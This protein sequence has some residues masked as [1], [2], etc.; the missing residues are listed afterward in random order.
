VLAEGL[1]G[2]EVG[3][4]DLH[5]G[6]GLGLDGV[7]EGVGVVGEGPRVQDDG[8]KAL[9]VGLLDPVYELA[10]VVALPEDH[11]Q[12]QL[13]PPGLA[14]GLQLLQGGPSVKLGL[15]PSQE[16]QVGAVQDQDHWP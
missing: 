12:A 6:K 5:H 15:P 11:A 10:L 8:Q 4:V 3:E 9:L 14:E 2:V 16:V 13:R 1:P 7:Q